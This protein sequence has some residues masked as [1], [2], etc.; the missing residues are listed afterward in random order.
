MSTDGSDNSYY[1]AGGGAGGIS[2]A[3]LNP[4]AATTSSTETASVSGNGETLM[5]QNG[6]DSLPPET[7]SPFES[8]SR[9]LTESYRPI[10]LATAQADPALYP[11]P[12]LTL[13]DELNNPFTGE[14]KGPRDTGDRFASS[15]DS[16]RSAERAN[17]G[18]E[19]HN[20]ETVE[21]MN[22]VA[23]L[24]AK[25]SAIPGQ[26]ELTLERLKNRTAGVV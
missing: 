17:D 13:V 8:I 16:S 22:G 7:K 2:F 20:R 11:F 23:A 9:S 5:Q 15:R 12:D 24:C 1:N 18:S 19:D 21:A 14:T 25:D 3:D 6:S 4:P 26:L 10:D